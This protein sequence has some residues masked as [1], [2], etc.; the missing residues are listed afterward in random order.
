MK[1][2]AASRVRVPKYAAART[3]DV[4]LTFDD[5]P[6]PK[7]TEVVLEVLQQYKI[8]AMFFVIGENVQRL[9]KIVAKTNKL[10]HRIGNHTFTHPHLS[11]LS[12]SKMKAEIIKTEDLIRPYL[13][14]GKILRPPYGDHSVLVD[15]VAAELGYRLVFWNVDTLDWNKKYQPDGWEQL[16][17]D[18][19]RERD[20]SIVL[21]HDIHVTTAE[22]LEDFIKR[23]IKL[24]NVRFRSP[25]D[26]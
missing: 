24:G 5:G 16:G 17:I 12:A 15:Q 21:N 25:F 2:K 9:P 18:Q 6:H 19:I 23:I 7:Q 8:A 20:S 14:Q 3:K 11:R 1:E 22:H 13:T 26:M 10:G 4:L